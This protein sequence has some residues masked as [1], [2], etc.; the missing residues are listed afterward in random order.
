[1]GWLTWG[2]SFYGVAFIRSRAYY[3]GNTVLQY[4]AHPR[5]SWLRLT[6]FKNVVF[7]IFCCE[8]VASSRC[9]C[10]NLSKSPVGA[11]RPPCMQH[12]NIYFQELSFLF[13]EPF[14]F[15]HT[16]LDDIFLAINLLS[17]EFLM[18]HFKLF[19][20]INLLFEYRKIFL[21]ILFSL[22]AEFFL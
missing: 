10:R 19:Q 1:M 21:K 9:R 22:F 5:A 12:R 7:K 8:G 18:K 15:P 16:F 14:P 3:M 17:I 2:T 6:S 20:K 11:E 4:I 13:Q